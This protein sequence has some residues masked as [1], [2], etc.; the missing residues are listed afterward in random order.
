MHLCYDYLHL[1]APLGGHCG[2]LLVQSLV[3]LISGIGLNKVLYFI[4][5]AYVVTPEGMEGFVSFNSMRLYPCS[6][7]CSNE[8]ILSTKYCEYVDLKD[9]MTQGLLMHGGLGLGFGL[10]YFLY[11]LSLLSLLNKLSIVWPKY[12]DNTFLNTYTL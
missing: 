10:I 7:T 9:K 2:F 3:V 11:H 8:L 1:L 4:T 12:C 6:V 5:R